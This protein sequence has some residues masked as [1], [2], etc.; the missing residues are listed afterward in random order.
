MWCL[1]NDSR[2][3]RAESARVKTRNLV[4]YEVNGASDVV[5]EASGVAEVFEFLRAHFLSHRRE[6]VGHWFGSVLYVTPG[7]QGAA[8][9]AGEDEGEIGMGVAVA[10]G[11]AAA[12]EDHRIVQ[13]GIAIDVFGRL[14]FLEEF[15]ELLRV[16]TID[17][18]QF[19]DF[20]FGV[21]MM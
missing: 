15:A 2:L 17:L 21:E 13:K 7:T 18:H 4:F 3:Q 9:F 14:E 12:V 8:A 20:F 11:V 16:P 5:E 10:I 1:G 19:P 6:E